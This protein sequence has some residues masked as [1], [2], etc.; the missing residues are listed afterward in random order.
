LTLAV[1]KAKTLAM[2]P[3][4]LIASLALAACGSSEGI[5]DDKL[6]TLVIA[7]K[8]KHDPI[9]VARAA[10]DP[11][12]LGRA[13]KLPYRDVVAALGPHTYTFKSTNTVDEAGKRVSDLSD[14]TRLELGANNAFHGTYNN[15]AD[16]GREAIFEGGKLYLRPRYQR[17][18]G[19]APETPDE[20]AQIRDAYF[21]S[22]AATWDLIAPAAELTDQGA[23]TIAGRPGRKIAVKQ[24]PSPRPNP[25]EPL[26]QRKWR[27][28]RMIEGVSGEVV[29][30]AEK[31]VPLAV[32]LAGTIS[33]SRDGRR[34]T[35]KLTL[36]AQLAAVG[37]VAIAAPPADQVVATPERLRE[38]DDRDFLLQGIAPP[39]RKNS[40]TPQPSGSGSK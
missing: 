4:F 12:E 24:A 32:K 10:R 35:M 14:E 23:T 6:G 3:V 39:L 21:D 19:R 16:Y 27:E 33:F 30:D 22:I 13:L 5:P 28:K 7:P 17:F 34:F 20:P 11:N 9:D 38:V 29:L 31:G 15:S 2:R 1:E 36:D 25:T 8:E 18:H 26:T 37:A 40:D